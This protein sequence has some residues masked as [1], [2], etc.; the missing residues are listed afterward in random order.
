MGLKCL[1][2]CVQACVCDVFNGL[3]NKSEGDSKFLEMQ[4]MIES[5]LWGMGERVVKLI[6]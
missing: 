5:Q 6:E 3:Q 1:S 4:Q 2:L